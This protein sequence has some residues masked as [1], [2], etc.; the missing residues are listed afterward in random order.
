MLSV[1]VCTRPAVVRKKPPP[2]EFS[3]VSARVVLM[4]T[5]QSLSERDLAA[6]SNDS[7]SSSLRRWAK[8]SWI[9]SLVIDCNHSLCTG[10]LHSAA[11]I[12]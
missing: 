3:A 12:T 2:L 9:A 5:S 4:P 1:G 8:P 6:S 7:I 11:S 10:F